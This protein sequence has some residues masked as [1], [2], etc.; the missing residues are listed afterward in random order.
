[1]RKI[2]FLFMSNVIKI[3]LVLTL[4]LLFFSVQSWSQAVFEIKSPSKA[5][6]FY[7][8]GYGDSTLNM[9]WGNGV[10][11]KKAVTGNLAIATGVD[12]LAGNALVGNYQ[13]KILLVHRGGGFDFAIKTL[14]AQNAGAIAVIIVNHG[15]VNG[16]VDSVA[17]LNP[18]GMRANETATT[19]T[20]LQVHIPVIVIGIKDALKIKS[21]IRSE[22]TVTA[23]LGGKQMYNYDLKID[24]AVGS[25]LYRTRPSFLVKAGM[26]SDT[27]GMTIYNTGTNAM[28]NVQGIVTVNKKGGSVLFTDKYS[29]GVLEG[30]GVGKKDTLTIKFAKPFKTNSDL[31]KGTYEINYKLVT[32]KSNSSDTVLLDSYNVDNS[33]TTNFEITDSTYSVGNLTSY[34]STKT[35]TNEV[36][37]YVNQPNWSTATRSSTTGLFKSCSSL[38]NSDVNGYEISGINFLA[39]YNDANTA[40]D[41][42]LN[43]TVTIEV[44]ENNSNNIIY[45]YDYVFDKKYQ[46]H[47]GNHKLTPGSLVLTNNSNYFVCVSSSDQTM[48][49]GYDRGISNKLTTQLNNKYLS[50]N[51]INGT[52]YLSGFGLDYVSAI[53]VD[54]S[55]V[56][57]NEKELLSFKLAKPDS[58]KTELNNST[59]SILVPKGTD[60]TKLVANFTHSPLSKVFVNGVQ[61]TSGVTVNNFLNKT[62][63][64]VVVA[65]DGTKQSYF[66]Q[67][68]FCGSYDNNISLSQE[69]YCPNQSVNFYLSNE[70]EGEKTFYFGNGKSFVKNGTYGDAMTSYDKKGEYIAYVTYKNIT[71]FN[72]LDTSYVLV[73]I[74]DTIQPNADFYVDKLV[75]CPN[76]PVSLSADSYGE[77]SYTWTM[78][79]GTTYSDKYINHTYTTE[80]NNL[81]KLSVTNSCG[82]T[83]TISKIIKVSKKASNYFNSSAYIYGTSTACIG[84]PISFSTSSNNQ[85]VV[86]DFKDNSATS[87]VNN[88]MHSFKSAGDYLVQAKLTN[89]CG[90]DTIVRTLVTIKSAM[91]FTNVETLSDVSLCPG[92]MHRLYYSTYS[93]QYKSIAWILPGNVVINNDVDKSFPMGNNLVQLKLTN[94]C[95]NDTLISKKI[96]VKNNLFVSSNV[97][98]G[99]SSTDEYCPGEEFSQSVY[100][101]SYNSFKS[102]IWSGEGLSSS[103]KGYAYFKINTPGE[104]TINAKLTNYCGKDTTISKKI[105]IVN[106]KKVETSFNEYYLDKTYCPGQEV[107]LYYNGS[108]AA[109]KTSV[110]D[111][112]DNTSG[113]ST[114][115]IYKQMGNYTVKLKLTNYCNADTTIQ[116]IVKI[117]QVPMN[118]NAVI[119]IYNDNYS[120]NID[121]CKGDAIELS[122]N[123]NSSNSFK[124]ISWNFGDGTS[125]VTDSRY[126]NH[127]FEKTGL[128]TVKATLMNFCGDTLTISKQINIRT[129]VAYKGRF[130]LDYSSEVC[131]NEMVN[132]STGENFKSISWNFGDNNQAQGSNVSHAYANLGEYQLK[133]TLKNSCNFDTTLTKVIVVSKDVTPD[134]YI[135]EVNNGMICPGEK[136]TLYKWSESKDYQYTYNFGD[137]TA[138][139]DEV[140]LE[141][142][143]SLLSHKY[144][145]VGDYKII[146]SA[147]N[148]CGLT[149]KDS[150]QIKVIDGLKIA[151]SDVELDDEELTKDT[152]L[153]LVSTNGLQYVWN[154]GG[155]NT[156]KTDVPFIKHIFKPNT[157]DR[158]SVF[159]TTACGDT[160]TFV[161]YYSNVDT[162]GTST[163]GIEESRKTVLNIYPNPTT[164]RFT[165][166]G[167]PI[168]QYSLVNELGAIVYSFEVKELVDQ[169]IQI[170]NL[171]KGLYFL[172][173]SDTSFVQEKIVV[174]E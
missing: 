133:V 13:G 69:V 93:N 89:Y 151:K 6:G 8:F 109:I 166:S 96:T 122:I 134:F 95:G 1:M 157:I 146:V 114:S 22:G 91:P 173:G 78:G 5:K 59:Y 132:F 32:L 138:T 53:S 56:K 12:S 101:D 83:S 73:N 155:N 107:S 24:P 44:M 16:S 27:L 103:D 120:D 149:A 148:K 41:Y 67:V 165:I 33:V 123:D 100:V 35:N 126:T 153:F 98:F 65:E 77:Q 26:V 102:F 81:V 30:P 99:Y 141:G 86:W 40:S 139:F 94:Y 20:G 55:K 119:S 167:A 168:G 62:L 49:F 60:L 34:S 118:K 88:P 72:A 164:G 66:V 43:K 124:S 156:V 128:L 2:K 142:T 39:Y 136:V 38:Q 14:N 158:V 58:T 174:I 3:R 17:L 143:A 129:D 46:H 52:Q 11:A 111:Y 28:N 130:D 147:K 47:Y 75:L 172:K 113:T 169:T 25:P 131:P 161:K 163:T 90:I 51:I 121:Y 125:A 106:S 54:L 84:Q 144:K 135:G 159:V 68:D 36:V 150:V 160:A 154:F 116:G 71:C 105:K 82:N 76:E 7:S 18:S 57:S 85:S 137:Q 4:V 152:S 170:D 140:F 115:H 19:A 63:E 145:S 61:Q 171:S 15:Q 117:N 42:L 21:A 70:T 97:G 45:T 162:T 23:Y 74:S 64:Y 37:N 80:G 112:G 110:F 29:V 9:G 104:Y 31:E 48:L 10:L 108:S 92:E 79:D 127:M 50:S 87:S